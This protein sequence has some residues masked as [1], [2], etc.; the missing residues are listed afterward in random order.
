MIDEL[1]ELRK[2]YKMQQEANGLQSP[3]MPEAYSTFGDGKTPSL[4]FAQ[5]APNGTAIRGRKQAAPLDRG[6]LHSRKKSEPVALNK[7][8]SK[9]R[10]HNTTAVSNAPSHNDDNQSSISAINKSQV[11]EYNHAKY[12]TRQSASTRSLDNLEPRRAIGK[13]HD[14]NAISTRADAV[15][16]EGSE[17]TKKGRFKGRHMSKVESKN[18]LNI[19]LSRQA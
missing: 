11:D 7:L 9:S 18:A 10:K 19:K 2:E 3:S 4:G 15:I 5:L 13:R 16:F 1:R 17:G 6:S 14:R 12:L 8:E